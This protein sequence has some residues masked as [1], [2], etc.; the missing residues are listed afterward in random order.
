MTAKL[1]TRLGTAAATLALAAGLAA[2]RPAGSAEDPNDWPL[3]HRSA[4][5]ARHSPLKQITR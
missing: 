3:Y 4:D 1:R 5:G 2:S